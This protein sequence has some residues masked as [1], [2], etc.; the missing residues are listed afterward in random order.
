M[1]DIILIL[2]VF[3]LSTRYCRKKIDKNSTSDILAII[4]KNIGRVY[5]YSI[6]DAIEGNADDKIAT[7]VG[8]LPRNDIT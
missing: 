5:T 8:T 7:V 4:T 1:L 3:N 6:V 2:A